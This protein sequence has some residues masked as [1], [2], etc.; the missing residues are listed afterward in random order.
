MFWKNY[1]KK[2]LLSNPYLPFVFPHKFFNHQTE[3]F[4]IILGIQRSGNHLII[5]WLSKGLDPSIHMNNLNLQ[6]KDI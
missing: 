6:K 5:N 3:K 4:I 2:R 1:L